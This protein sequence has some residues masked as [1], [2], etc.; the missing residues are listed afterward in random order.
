M[1]CVLCTATLSSFPLRSVRFVQT[2]GTDEYPS[3]EEA[4][5]VFLKQAGDQAESISS[6]C[7]ACAG[8]VVDNKCAMTNLKWVV[9]GRAITQEFGFRTAVCADKLLQIWFIATPASV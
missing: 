7:L 8:P 1:L 6:C 5:R 4:M 9:D 2:L 3:F